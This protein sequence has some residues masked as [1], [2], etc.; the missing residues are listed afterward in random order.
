ML[1]H[2]TW[3]RHTRRNGARNRTRRSVNMPAPCF[4]GEHSGQTSV[5]LGHYKQVVD[6]KLLLAT[7]SRN[8]QL[9]PSSLTSVR[10]IGSMSFYSAIYSL[11]TSPWAI[12]L[13]LMFLSL[14]LRY[15]TRTAF[16]YLRP[17][18][19]K[20]FLEP[21]R[22]EHR[23]TLADLDWMLHMNN[24]RYLRHCDIARTTFY[25]SNN[26]WQAA[27]SLGAVVVVASS[28][29]RYRRSIPP[30]QAYSIITKLVWWDEKNLYIEQNF[31]NPKNGFIFATVYIK[32]A[33]VNCST[34]ALLTRCSEMLGCAPT[35]EPCAPLDLKAWIQFQE[36]SS[37][38]LKKSC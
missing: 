4:V 16:E 28:T 30:F 2:G 34:P 12:V 19:N 9:K 6:S 22:S 20:H 21:H 25:T 8:L 10:T 17:K 37:D 24:G 33:T 36:L 3:A 14:D 23:C 15:F 1:S 32:G 7:C 18:R 38:R 31:L 27:K 29:I 26:L 35:T 5:L 11:V 13:T